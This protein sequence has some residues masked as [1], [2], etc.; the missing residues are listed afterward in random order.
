ML[1]TCNADK[2]TDE[3]TVF[4]NVKSASLHDILR[5]VLKDVRTVSLEKD[6][7]VILCLFLI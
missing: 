7:S 1:L 2:K 5:I 3:V 4:V 6:K